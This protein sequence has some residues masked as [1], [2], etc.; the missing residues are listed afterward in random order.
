MW[1]VL[2]FYEVQNSGW[3][4]KCQVW[5]SVR[6]GHSDFSGFGTAILRIRSCCP[7][8]MRGDARG[9]LWKLTLWPLLSGQTTALLLPEERCT[10]GAG[11]QSHNTCRVSELSCPHRRWS[12]RAPMFPASKDTMRLIPFAKEELHLCFLLTGNIS[13]IRSETEQNP[14]ALKPHL[15]LDNLTLKEYLTKIILTFT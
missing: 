2:I 7:G 14:K 4:R 8:G 5:Q 9:V 15:S 6:K 12:D 1:A 11:R 3:L 10:L 13:L